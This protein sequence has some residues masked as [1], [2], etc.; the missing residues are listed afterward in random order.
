MAFLR[1][2][3]EKT[4]TREACRI[5]SYWVVVKFQIPKNLAFGLVLCVSR[6]M[7]KRLSKRVTPAMEAGLS[8]QVWRLKE[9]VGLIGQAR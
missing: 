4:K 3:C 8:D 7:P 6:T 2:D 1:R 9:I 5:V